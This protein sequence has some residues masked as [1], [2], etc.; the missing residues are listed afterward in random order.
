[1][2][3]N[4]EYSGQCATECMYSLRRASGQPWVTG[5]RGYCW[6]KRH[7]LQPTQTPTRER[8]RSG[9]CAETYWS[10]RSDLKRA[11]VDYESTRSG[12]GREPSKCVSGSLLSNSDS[13]FAVSETSPEV[14]CLI[15]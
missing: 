8:R 1:M 9:R 15:R 10:R 2:S 12:Q 6:G 7:N 4:A 11:P 13:F 5:T 3:G 14:E